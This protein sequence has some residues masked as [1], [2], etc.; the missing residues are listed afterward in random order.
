M[1]KY[2]KFVKENSRNVMII[3]SNNQSSVEFF[4]W[5]VKMC[6]LDTKLKNYII[7]DEKKNE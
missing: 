4:L 6:I 2:K 1:P 3:V 7:K 5:K